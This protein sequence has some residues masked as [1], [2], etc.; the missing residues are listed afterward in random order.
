MMSGKTV[1]FFGFVLYLGS[2]LILSAG[3]SDT[4]LEHPRLVPTT[5]SGVGNVGQDSS[6]TIG[7]EGLALISYRDVTNRPL[8]MA[9]CANRACTSVTLTPRPTQ[10]K[11][12]R[13]P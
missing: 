5:L 13:S 9:R 1:L 4:S 6:L 3:A 10:T 7:T 11:S 8:K 12:V 2:G